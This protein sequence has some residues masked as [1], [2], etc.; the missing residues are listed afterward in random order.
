M[1]ASTTKQKT[2]AEI[3]A[4]WAEEDKQ[5]SGEGISDWTRRV[6]DNAENRKRVPTAITMDT[7]GNQLRQTPNEAKEQASKESE[8]LLKGVEK[9][10]SGFGGRR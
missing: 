10:G 9:K 7:E 1:S 2:Q 6:Q 3:E 4:E 5:K 8:G